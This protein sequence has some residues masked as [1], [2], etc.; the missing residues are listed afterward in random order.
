MN[1]G[2][3]LLGVLADL[4][5]NPKASRMFRAWKSDISMMPEGLLEQLEDAVVLDLFAYLTTTEPLE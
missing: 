4:C 5:R 3:Q 1:A 2:E